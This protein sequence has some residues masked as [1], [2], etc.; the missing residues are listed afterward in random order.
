[1][2]WDRSSKTKNLASSAGSL[3]TVPGCRLASSATT[4]WD[5][6][7][8]WW[9]C[10]STLGR[11]AMKLWEIATRASLPGCAERSCAFDPRRHRSNAHDLLR[12]AETASRGLFLRRSTECQDHRFE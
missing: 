6:E 4:R 2:K 1:M 12:S 5:T 11:P 3:G 9:T 10:S 8:T 7:P